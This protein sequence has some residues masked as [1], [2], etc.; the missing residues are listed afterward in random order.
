MQAENFAA[1]YGLLMRPDHAQYAAFMANPIVVLSAFASELFLKCLLN[2]EGK[3]FERTHNL[4]DLFGSLSDSTRARITELW[5]AEVKRKKA[6]WAAA[7]G[8]NPAPLDLPTALKD[9]GDA[10][11][12]VRY[13]HEGD[14]NC[15]FVMGDLP[16]LLRTVIVEKKPE[17][18]KV[19]RNVHQKIVGG[20]GVTQTRTVGHT[21]GPDIA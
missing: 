20:I 2:L 17:W 5:D 1:C 14:V 11:D 18:D 12:A 10:F 6:D 4:E 8:D 15:R 21:Q 19:Q 16:R 9:G 7:Q 13:A 3:E